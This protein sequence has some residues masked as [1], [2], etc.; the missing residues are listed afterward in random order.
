MSAA[1]L[2]H[3]TTMF[4]GEVHPFAARFPMLPDEDIQALAD[5]IAANGLQHPIILDRQGVLIDG[6][7]RLA[8]CELAGIT[9]IF[10]VR[11]ADPIALILSHNMQ[12]RDLTQAQ[13]AHIAVAALSNL[14]NHIRQEDLRS[15]AGVPQSRIAE[16]AVI[17]RFL[18]ESSA[19]IIAGTQK[20]APAYENAK[21]E[22]E[23]L[24][25]INL[26]RAQLQREAPELLD[27]DI[28]HD[29]A[30]KELLRRRKRTEEEAAQRAENIRKANVSISESVFRLH[31]LSLNPGN[32]G[33]FIATYDVAHTIHPL[34]PAEIDAAIAALLTL[35]EH[36]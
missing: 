21:A 34:D 22:K 26:E 28:P 30:W 25:R 6:R 3:E 32:V 14:D 12:R 18:P 4:S 20:H 27:P 5:D 13:K 17:A 33:D 19:A 29:E 9:P 11:D 24:A 36:L 15:L 2:V 1:E 10:E 31:L 7:N 16:A 35:R 23:R 8:A